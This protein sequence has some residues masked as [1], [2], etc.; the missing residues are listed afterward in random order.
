[1]YGPCS[2]PSKDLPYSTRFFS[3]DKRNSATFSSGFS[4]GNTLKNSCDIR[5]RRRQE[6]EWVHKRRGSHH[7]GG[8]PRLPL[9]RTAE[10]NACDLRQISTLGVQLRQVRPS[11]PNSKSET[12]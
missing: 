6:A 7:C 1:M 9:F 3:R 10:R 12:S 2:G 11:Q 8:L 5:G 4:R